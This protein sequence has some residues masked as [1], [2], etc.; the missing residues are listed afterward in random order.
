MN[1]DI[2]LLSDLI[3]LIKLFIRFTIDTIL[4]L[5]ALI[6]MVI[7]DLIKLSLRKRETFG[8]KFINFIKDNKIGIIQYILL[9]VSPPYSILWYVVQVYTCIT[10][11]NK[12]Q[13]EN[14]LNLI[15]FGINCIYA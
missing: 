1:K 11:F 6:I 13:F 7:M 15:P 3:I 8:E 14:L 10:S 2:E 4:Y 12:S 5:I 9:L